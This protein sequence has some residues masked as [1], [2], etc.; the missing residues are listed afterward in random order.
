[1][2][3]YLVK[4]NKCGKEYRTRLFTPKDQH[5]KDNCMGFFKIVEVLEP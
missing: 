3:K 1:M 5:K 4:C 2:P